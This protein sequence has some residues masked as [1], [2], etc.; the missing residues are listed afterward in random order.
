MGRVRTGTFLVPPHNTGS[1]PSGKG[2]ILP[3]P[4]WPDYR[5]LI[6]AITPTLDEKRLRGLHDFVT[7]N[8]EAFHQNQRVRDERQQLHKRRQYERFS[9]NLRIVRATAGARIKRE[10]LDLMTE[11]ESTL[12]SDGVYKK[13]TL[14]KSTGLWTAYS[15]VVVYQTECPVTDEHTSSYRDEY[16]VVAC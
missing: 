8:H 14:E 2:L 5:T 7:D 11:A 1:P 13:I 12:L 6:D 16:G 3:P 10:G 9:R 4:V 15:S